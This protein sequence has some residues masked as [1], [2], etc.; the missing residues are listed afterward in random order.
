MNI[1]RE[2]FLELHE[3]KDSD[4]INFLAVDNS[5]EKVSDNYLKSI[6]EKMNALFSPLEIAIQLKRAKIPSYKISKLLGINRDYIY[7]I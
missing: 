7:K 4:L 2:Q 3:S 6:I 1:S 5:I